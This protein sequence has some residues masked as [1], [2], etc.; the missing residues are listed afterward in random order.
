MFKE[1][2]D[3]DANASAIFHELCKY[4]PNEESKELPASTR[5][6]TYIGIEITS[7]ISQLLKVV[8]KACK[9]VNKSAS[10]DPKEELKDLEVFLENEKGKGWKLVRSHHVTA[11]FI[12]GNQ[13]LTK[14]EVFT[15]FREDEKQIVKLGAVVIV[16]HKC[17]FGLCFVKIP[18]ANRIPHITLV[19]NHCPAKNSN[20]Y[21][22][23]LFLGV[24]ELRKK[25]EDGWFEKDG[26]EYLGRH[27][28]TADGKK[29]V[30]YVYKPKETLTL[31]GVSKKFH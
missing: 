27:E 29:C 3:A 16:P 21:G 30:A 24:E 22:E 7:P 6:P 28:I 20:L 2:A 5:V 9:E 15:C 10:I 12:G 26:E 11:L 19:L 18:I 25:Y 14:S 17:V 1:E 23:A 13:E 31:Y 8:E 4:L